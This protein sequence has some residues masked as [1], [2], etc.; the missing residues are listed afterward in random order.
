M[1][2]RILLAYKELTPHYGLG[3]MTM[4]EVAARA[5]VSKRTLYRYFPSKEVLIREFIGELKFA[6]GQEI[7]R[8][9]ASDLDVEQIITELLTTLR[10]NAQFMSSP[11][12]VA[13]M[14]YRYPQ[15]WQEVEQFRQ[16][17]LRE[18]VAFILGGLTPEV[19]PAII[20]TV[21]LTTVREILNPDFII[22]NNLVFEDATQQVSKLLLRIIK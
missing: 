13:D 6:M 18:L 2:E 16:E 1:R 20:T 8:L 3:G 4:D 14:R 19:A 17:R 5:G 22:S 12:G 15:L 11:Q 7:Q 9:L 10:S 21:I